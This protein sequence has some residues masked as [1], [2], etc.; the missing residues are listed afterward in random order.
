MAKN[1]SAI[2]EPYGQRIGLLRQEMTRR[3]LDGYLILDRLDQIWLTGFTGEDGLV[4][5]SPSKIVLLTDGRFSEAADRQAPYARKVLRKQRTA[6]VNAR[7]IGK[8]KLRRIGFDPAQLSV[9]DHSEL[10]KRL[11]PTKLVPAGG[12]VAQ[13]RACKN[14]GE[15]RAVQLAIDVAQTAFQRLREWLRFG[16]TE[17]EIAARLEYE[18]K[19]LG[20]QGPSFPTIV[21]CGAN[22]SLPHY[23]VGDGVFTEE[24]VLLVDWGAQVGWY[25]SDLTRVIWPPQ[26]PRELVDIFRVVQAAHD[27]AIAAARP[28]MTAHELDRVARRVIVDAGYGK[29]FNHATGHGLGLAVHEVPRVGAGTKVELKPGMIITVEPGI[30]LPGIGGVR[31]EDDILITED[32]HQVLSSLPV[33]RP[34]AGGRA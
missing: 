19:S 4:L 22:S 23:E 15:V 18:M 17:R 6:E 24:S 13:M 10:S 33:D 26:P 34:A 8:F 11:R 9:A 21:A 7:Q 31:I 2:P 12:I 20:A 5:V 29:Q 1:K 25:C 16:K 3:G 28:G 32:G 14:D 27:E 30:Y